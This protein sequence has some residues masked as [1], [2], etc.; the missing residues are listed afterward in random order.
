M[1]GLIIHVMQGFL[2]PF[3]LEYKCRSQSKH[4]KKIKK[5][6]GKY[7]ALYRVNMARNMEASRAETL[8]TAGEA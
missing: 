1:K 2:S 5:K 3:S 6:K 4:L 7:Y 8:Q